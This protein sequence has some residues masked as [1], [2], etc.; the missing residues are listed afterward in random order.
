M[1]GFFSKVTKS[2]DEMLLSGQKDIDEQFEQ[3]KLFLVDYH[4]KIA[5][6][7]DLADRMTKTTKGKSLFIS[8]V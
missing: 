7:T 2:A 6:S 1:G 5:A 3:D 8:F 4:K